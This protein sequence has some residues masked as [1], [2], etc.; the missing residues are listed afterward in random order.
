MSQP[1]PDGDIHDAERWRSS[2]RFSSRRSAS[3]SWM[4]PDFDR[5]KNDLLSS[6]HQADGVSGPI[7]EGTT[8]RAESFTGT[9]APRLPPGRVFAGVTVTTWL[10]GMSASS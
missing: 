10:A 2:E 6:A 5:V 9:A 8:W 7:L 4:T 1:A 3:N